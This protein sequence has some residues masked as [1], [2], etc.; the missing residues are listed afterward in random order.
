MSQKC[1][2]LT[3]ASRGLVNDGSLS[4]GLTVTITL[5]SRSSKWGRGSFGSRPRASVWRRARDEPQTAPS[6]RGSGAGGRK[7]G[8]FCGRARKDH[9]KLRRVNRAFGVPQG[10]CCVPFAH[11]YFLFLKAIQHLVHAS[12]DLFGWLNVLA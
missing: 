11:I 5:L 1:S 9:N 4:V 3:L 12:L 8:R 6:Q 10:S 2:F 7:G